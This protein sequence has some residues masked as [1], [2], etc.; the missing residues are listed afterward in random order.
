MLHE[1]AITQ[2]NALIEN[3]KKLNPKKRTRGYECHH[4]I[5]KCKSLGGSLKD[6]ENLVYLTI[7]EHVVAHILL[8]DVYET[9]RQHYS[10]CYA[11]Q[12]MFYVLSFARIDIPLWSQAVD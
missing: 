2:Y 4:I 8:C 6:P 7:R 3:A 5:P 12:M 9:G 10:M 11:L 1:D